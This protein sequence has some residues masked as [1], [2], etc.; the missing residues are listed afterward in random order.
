MLTKKDIKGMFD[1]QSRQFDK[2]LG[3]LDAKLTQKI[4]PLAKIL[5]QVTALLTHVVQDVDELKMDMKSVKETVSSH[6]TT[7]DAILKNTET[8]KTEKAA[9]KATIDRHERWF[10]QIAE[11]IHIELER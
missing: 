1:A 6:T 5:Q 2:K 3:F 9:F 11:K 7:L 8:A 10:E 4:D